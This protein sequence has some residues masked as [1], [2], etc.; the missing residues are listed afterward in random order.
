MSRTAS[1]EEL[2]DLGLVLSCRPPTRLRLYV[3]LRVAA[4]EIHKNKQSKFVLSPKMSL[5]EPPNS[6]LVS[7]SSH[8]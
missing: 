3:L 7:L 1:S 5:Q 8:A 2:Q 6:V 4:Q